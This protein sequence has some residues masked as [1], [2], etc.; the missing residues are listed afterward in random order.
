MKKTPALFV[1]L[2]TAA[3]L[4][5]THA[6]RVVSTNDE[7]IILEPAQR[8]LAGAR[9]YVDFFGY[10][11]PGSY[12]L[13][14]AVF[15]ICGISLWAGRLVVILDFSVQTALIFWLVA[16][17]ASS[18][19]AA[20]AAVTF[21]GFQIADPNF[22]TSQHRW[23][24]ATLALA[25]L[26]L[27]LQANRSRTLWIASGALMAAAA[28]CTPALAL[29]GAALA[30]WLL[31]DSTRRRQ[32]I[33]WTIGAAAV[34]LL[35]VC[36][37]QMTASLGAFIQQLAW[38]KTNYSLVN[39]MPY[40]AVI[41]GYRALLDGASG[42]ELPMRAILVLCLALPAILPI[43]ALA[44]SA[45]ALARVKVP[46][47]HR[48][49]L[50]LLMLAVIAFVVTVFPRADVMHLAFIAALPYGLTAIA[51]SWLMPA[52]VGMAIATA[53]MTLASLFGANFFLALRGTQPVATPVGNL[54]VSSDHAQATQAWLAAVHPGDSLFVYPYMP[55]G[56][57]L[58]QARNP[59]RFS[60]LAPGM[61][62]TRE[63]SVAL[64]ELQNDPPVWL[65][66]L[67][68]PRGEFL[69]VFPNASDLDW[70]FH[71]LEDWLEQNYEPAANPPV[72]VFGYQLW[73]RIPGGRSARPP[74]SA[75]VSPKYP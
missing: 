49:A 43:A 29:A 10:M 53:A 50:H 37:L 31:L 64:Q 44:F 34:T 40:G 45:I 32:L 47:Q 1:F 73:R 15:R 7:G 72:T 75:L 63:E 52:R 48:P 12:W 38:L 9:P 6:N 66:Y 54:R 19:A 13:Q 39:I 56:Y 25:G 36:R 28:W 71:A 21:A 18:R 8:M 60:F 46:E 59:T 57:F 51:L 22:L 27:A 26:C 68:L 24:S 17:L 20:A 5:A 65:A 14:A 4:L 35:A 23:D 2:I 55:M 62:T 41:G 69:R 16:R 3:I 58:T 30:V 61:M 11:S 42:P 33:P 70:H 74:V 67:K